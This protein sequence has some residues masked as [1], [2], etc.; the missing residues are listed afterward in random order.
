MPEIF[1]RFPTTK[2]IV[3]FLYED[4]TTRAEC[5]TMQNRILENGSENDCC[6]WCDDTF[7]WYIACDLKSAFDKALFDHI[8]RKRLKTLMQKYDSDSVVEFTDTYF[9]HNHRIPVIHPVGYDDLGLFSKII[10][11]LLSIFVVDRKSYRYMR[12]SLRD[13]NDSYYKIKEMTR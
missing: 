10:H 11:K 12:T 8:E 13:L 1:M 5:I 4:Y 6:C 9:Y 3:D 2:E 7:P